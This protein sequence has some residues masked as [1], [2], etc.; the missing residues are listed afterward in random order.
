MKTKNIHLS[1]FLQLFLAAILLLSCSQKGKPSSKAE[2]KSLLE[3]Q[4]QILATAFVA[5]DARKLAE[6][7]TDSARLSPDGAH[8]IVGR[9]SIRAFWSKDFKSSKVL[10]MKTNVLT[11]EGNEDLIYETGI[12]VSDILYK[13]SVYKP[14][15]K[16][17]NIWAKQPNGSYKLDVDFWNDDKTE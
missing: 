13:D 7:Y 4:N 11:V 1:H 2:M 10:K 9:D 3:K 16:Y 12:T 15:I 14:R 5:G 6:M 8:F 17:V